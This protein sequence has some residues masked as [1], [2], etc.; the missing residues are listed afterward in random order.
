MKKI[1]VI[2]A[3][4][5][6]GK[7][8]LIRKLSEHRPLS[9]SISHTTRLPRNE[10]RDGKD[11]HFISKEQFLR[12]K[13]EGFFLESAEIYGNYYAT[14]WSNILDHGTQEDSWLLLDLDPQGYLAIRE[15]I[16]N[17]LSVFVLPPSLEVLRLRILMRQPNI[18]PYE[19]ELRLSQ[20]SYEISYAQHYHHKILNEN[21]DDATAAL[22]AMMDQSVLERSSSQQSV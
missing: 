5:G 8:T 17:V 1:L 15:K 22:I 12:L 10:E 16:P 21:I 4:S 11:Y 2:S 7:T 13:S 9:Y 19:L 3:P 20:A 18:C 6:A 14:A